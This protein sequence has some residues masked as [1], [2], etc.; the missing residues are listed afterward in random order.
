MWH[1]Q[2]FFPHHHVE[3]VD[4]AHQDHQQLRLLLHPHPRPLRVMRQWKR[5]IAC[6]DQDAVREVDAKGTAMNSGFAMATA[7]LYQN[8]S[9]RKYLCEKV[10]KGLLTDLYNIILVKFDLLS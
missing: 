6:T 2:D 3:V 7:V 8:D 9:K 4:A 1:V 5:V 10:S